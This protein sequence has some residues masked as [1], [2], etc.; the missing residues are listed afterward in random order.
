MNGLSARIDVSR[1][2]FRLHVDIVAA[3]GRIT[4]VLGP[5][6]SGKTTL[7]HTLAGL[8]PVDAGRIEISGRVLDDPAESVF[9]PAEHR[10]TGLVFQD[11]LLFPHL[12]VQANVEFG[13][14]SLG[15]PEPARRATEWLD[16]LD[17]ADLAERRP[18]ALSGGQAQR[19]ALARALAA[20]PDMLLLDEPMAAL[21]A[22]TR[23]EVRRELRRHLREFTGPTLL[24]THDPLDALVLADDVV[25]LESGRVS[26]SGTTD[27]VGRRPATSYVATLMGANLLHAIAVDGLA[28]CTD[29]TTVAIPDRA[30]RGEVIVVIRPEAIVLHRTPPEGS[31]RNVWPVRVVDVETHLDRSLVQVAGPP[32][33]AVAVTA[34]STRDLGLAPGM[35]LWAS[36]K[37]LD[38]DAYPRSD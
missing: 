21:D 15:L 17:V 19:V 7:L 3:A 9:V 10:R 27:D 33:L 13:P 2:D 36:A 32:D 25:V 20:D 6:G 31:A 29:G 28:T 18:S 34:A 35:Q 11:F 37:A 16:R 26:Q 5:N 38:L 23:V 8:Q 12:S 30:L 24:V 1:G 22:S 4:A 14:R